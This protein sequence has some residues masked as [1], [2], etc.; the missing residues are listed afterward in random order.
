MANWNCIPEF[1]VGPQDLEVGSGGASCALSLARVEQESAFRLKRTVKLFH[2]LQHPPA[3]LGVD[4]VGGD[5]DVVVTGTGD[6]DPLLG[7][8]GRKGIEEEFSSGNVS[9]LIRRAVGDQSRDPD[10]RGVLV[11][12]NVGEM[13]AGFPMIDKASAMGPCRTE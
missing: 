11:R 5:E 8:G 10:S 2:E 13:N 6:F 9:H 4:G 3:D 7:R 12:L 1:F